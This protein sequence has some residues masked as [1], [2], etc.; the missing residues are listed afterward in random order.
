MRIGVELAV[1]AT[2]N[3]L[4]ESLKAYDA[5][6][7]DR[8]WVPDSQISE[9][10]MWTVATLAAA[11][12]KRVRIGLG[13][14]SPYQRSPAVMAHAAATLD[15][16]SGGRIDITLGRGSR[17]YLKSIGEDGDDAGVQEALSILR[18]LLAGETVS[19]KGTVFNFEGVSLRTKSTQEVV[20]IFIAAMSDRWL[21][22]ASKCADGVHVYTSNPT[23]LSRVKK[24]AAS[25]G[26]GNFTIVTTLG[27]VEPMEV[28]RWWVTNFG[29]NYNLQQ[30]CGR[31]VGAAS[32]EELADELVFTDR[33]SLLNQV[34]RLEHLG[35]D[36]LMIAYRRPE[37]L[38]VIAELVRSI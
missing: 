5:Y 11:L 24:W 13:V 34:D 8:V 6:G 1:K 25:S 31:Q 17:D 37:D 33:F 7:F 26:K 32:Y 10:E 4:A 38:P 21:E 14:T 12:T 3:E 29:R 18:G 27:Y 22:V 9:W 30:L 19:R 16:L 15:Q 20:P 2:V 23:L 35:V 36:E 28:R